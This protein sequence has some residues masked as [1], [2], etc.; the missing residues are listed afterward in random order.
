MLFD[1]VK[2]MI[3]RGTYVKEDML[4]KMD[5]FLLNNRISDTEYNELVTLMG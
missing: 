3:T 5:V 2:T 4:K 1:L